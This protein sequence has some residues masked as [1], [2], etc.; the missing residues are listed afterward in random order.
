MLAAKSFGT[1]HTPIVGVIAG[2]L[3]MALSFW[4]LK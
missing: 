2:M 4:V 1:K 3:V